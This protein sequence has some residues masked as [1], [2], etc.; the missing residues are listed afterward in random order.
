MYYHLFLSVAKTFDLVH[1]PM[2]AVRIQ[3]AGVSTLAEARRLVALGVDGLGFT[4]RLPSGVHD[5]LTGEAAR[6]IVAAL[7]PLVG[8]VAITYIT[9]CAEAVAFCRALGV[10]TLQLH[11]PVAP[12]VITAI[13]AAEPA[14]KVIKSVNVT[15]QDSIAVALRERPL[16]ANTR[17][18]TAS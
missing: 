15:G 13:K 4:L 12:G 10:N 5:G 1:L 3:I 11:A 14:L 8:T 18:E 16:K 9:D 7:P 17:F 6:A 2:D